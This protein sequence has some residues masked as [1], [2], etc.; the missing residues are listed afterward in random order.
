VTAWAS[1]SKKEGGRADLWSPI[2]KATASITNNG[3]V[4]GA[5]VAQLYVTLPES[6]ESPSMQLRG[7]QKVF[8]QP[9]ETKA[10]EFVL[11]RRDLSV[12][13]VEQQNWRLEGGEYKIHLARSSR[14]VESSYSVNLTTV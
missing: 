11:Q 4:A 14:S 12:W 3:T 1:G 2:I 8:L 13:N 10:V 5:E 9:G 7:Y 6:A